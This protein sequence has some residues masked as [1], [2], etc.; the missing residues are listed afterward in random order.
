MHKARSLTVSETEAM[1]RFVQECLRRADD[2]E[3]NAKD[4]TDLEGTSLLRIIVWATDLGRQLRRSPR[5][6]ASIAVRIAYENSEG[7]WEENAKTVLISK[8]GASLRCAHPAKIGEVLQLERF[9]TGD[10]AQARIAWITPSGEDGLRI[11]L[12]F[13][14]CDNFWKLDWSAAENTR[15]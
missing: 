15:A 1:R 14:G 10:T 9:D 11:G 8:Y 3:H 7:S 2:V 5:K 6:A 4:L 13:I 12:E